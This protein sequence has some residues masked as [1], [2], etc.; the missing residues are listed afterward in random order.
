MSAHTFNESIHTTAERVIAF[1][2]NRDNAY[3]AISDL[4]D[5][6]FTSD[7]IGSMARSNYESESRN[8]EAG[9]DESFWE[10]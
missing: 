8:L 2:P 1:F 6:G 5:A 4:K 7:E 3:Q 10:N 9:R